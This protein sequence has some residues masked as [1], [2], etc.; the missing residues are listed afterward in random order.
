MNLF[1]II[2]L[3][4]LTTQSFAIEHIISA[5]KKYKIAPIELVKISI[6][7]SS[8]GKYTYNFNKNGTEDFGEFQ[9][10]SVH[11]N[12]T[13]KNYD[14]FSKQGNAFCAAKL[15]SLHKKWKLIDKNWVARYHSV[16]PKHKEKYAKKLKKIVIW[17]QLI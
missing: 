6:L 9:I 17:V 5:A 2:F 4:F 14:V 11:L 7:E 10:N 13:C 8:K 1:I 3:S 15:L 12:T 16:T